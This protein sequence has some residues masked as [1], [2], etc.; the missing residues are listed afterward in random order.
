MSA[1]TITPTQSPRHS[2]TIRILRSFL[3]L[4]IIV[5]FSL[6][7]RQVSTAQTGRQWYKTDLHVHSVLSADAYTDLGILS[8]SAK[9]QGY[10]AIFLTDHNLGSSFP[11]SSLTANYMIFEDTYRRWN[12]GSYGSPTSTTNVL[13]TS[14]INT[15]TKS[16]QLAS[17]AT[18]SGETHV[19]TNRGPNFRSGDIILK[20]SVYPTRIDTGSGVYVSASI[21]GDVT[22]HNPDGYTTSNGVISAGKSIVMIWQLGTARAA[23]SNPNQRVLTY[24]LTYTLNTWNHYTINI[25]DYLA[26]IPADELPLDYNGLTYL[27]MAAAANGGTANAY[28]DTYSITAGSPVPPADEFVYRTSVISTYDTSN[29][30]IFPSLEMGVSKHAQRFNF[31]I[32]DPS[33]FLSYWDGIDGIL[34]AQQSGYPSMLN[35]PGSDGGA[36]DQETISTQGHGADLI[37]VRQPGWIANWDAILQQGVQVL[38]SGTSDTHRGFSGSSFATYAYAP[39][40]TFDSMIRS[41]FEGQ[42][43]I[44]AGSFGDAG[45]MI[46]NLNSNSQ[47]P[48]PARYPVYVPGT[49]TSANVHLLV[50]GGL[51]SGYTIRWMR[52]GTQLVTESSAGA[53]Y[54][55]TKSI[56][57]GGAWTYVRAEI[58]DSSGGIK[59][60]T[61][62]LAFSV[63]AGLPADKSLHVAG[64]TTADGRKYT[65]LFIKGITAASWDGTLPALT[66][67]L[68]NPVN[69]LVDMRL[70]TAQAPGAVL[71][72]GSSIPA[73][74]SLATFQA[75]SSSVQYYHSASRMLYLKA[76]QVTDP[77]TVLISF[78][79]P[80]PATP[81]ATHTATHTATATATAT[82]SPTATSTATASPT[83]TLTNVPTATFADVSTGSPY[84]PYIETLYQSGITGGCGTSP[85]NYCPNSVV[86]RAQMAVFLLRAKHGS[87]YV[88]PAATGAVFTDVS[89]GH[90]AGAWIEQLF[91]E[92]ITGGC[93][94]GQYCPETAVTRDQMAVFLLRAEHGS[95]YVPPAASGTQF[96]D[97]PPGF[98]AGPWIEQLVAEA[99]T[100]G[101]GGGNYCPSVPVTRDQ[102]AVFLVKTFNL[103]GLAAGA[104]ASPLM[105]SP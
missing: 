22:V 1:R 77:T 80:G 60:L 10:N 101:C 81:T 37:E 38:G 96:A 21:G 95:G 68:Q 28:F 102:M 49:Q 58:R 42:T 84:W 32:T 100:A 87:G 71:V 94:G 67:T 26:D 97:V 33:Q 9:S 66:L 6:M 36:S 53:S 12:T 98:W 44:A 11:I 17:T 7:P 70:T 35:H 105:T 61:Q 85:L 74:D 90:W 30:K 50:T 16:L 63:V 99:I 3:V 55:A 20:F 24:P 79:D 69:A 46:L 43:Y 41:L 56:A 65:K 25:S 54:E 91:A 23:S 39:A 18:G 75:A 48:Y 29:F 27:K 14:R 40:L 103:G 2:R 8:Q 4:A 5:L 57:L 52:N 78:A 13:A 64:V 92:G 76:L 73:A 93:G 31:G 82:Q 34:P 51:K 104:N 19:W 45:Q 88:P 47:E 59:G 83:A 62:P 72:N 86:T 15:G 89:S